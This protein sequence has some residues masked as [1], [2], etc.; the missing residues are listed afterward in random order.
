MVFGYFLDLILWG[1]SW[2][3]PQNIIVKL[4]VLLAGC[5]VLGL[6]VSLEVRADAIMLPG[7][8]FV[9]AL[10]AKTG[11]EFGQ[12][13]VCSD[14]TMTVI[15]L[16]ISLLLFHQI[17]GVGAGTVIAAFLTG[18]AA[19]LFSRI[20]EP[21]LSTI[22]PREKMEKEKESFESSGN[23]LHQQII[24]TI[25][26]EYGC[27][28]SL[29]GKK[30]AEKLGISFYDSE[31]VDMAAEASGLTTEYILKNEER[32]TNSFLYDIYMQTYAYT[33]GEESKRDIMRHAQEAVIKKITEKESCVL[34]GRA[35]NY[36]LAGN[37]KAFHVFLY[38]PTV[39]I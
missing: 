13:K 32:L 28:A 35:A 2:L 14:A 11:R 30:V 18:A 26:R 1:L 3:T 17:R 36:V 8:G 6:G 5:A 37:E 23:T 33:S 25:G 39:M 7:E 31:L 22:L 20:L 9:K 19:N 24:I 10:S 12:M 15:A 38:A 27:G 4:L 34:M 21:S 16:F 29:I